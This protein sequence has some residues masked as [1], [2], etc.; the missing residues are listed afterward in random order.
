MPSPRRAR[1]LILSAFSS[2]QSKGPSAQILFFGSTVLRSGRLVG[3][4][5]LWFCSQSLCEGNLD[6]T[7]MMH[8]ADTKSSVFFWRSGDFQL[9]FFSPYPT[10]AGKWESPSLCRGFSTVLLRRRSSDHTKLRLLICIWLKRLTATYTQ[11]VL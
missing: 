7:L 10:L 4:L 9:D 8:L 2:A 6:S 3:L 1:R 5:L 11:Y